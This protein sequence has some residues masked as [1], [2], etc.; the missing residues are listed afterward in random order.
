MA[1]WHWKLDETRPFLDMS[2]ASWRIMEDFPALPAAAMPAESPALQ[3][4]PEAAP[5]P[6]PV[7]KLTLR[8]GGDVGGLLGEPQYNRIIMGL[9][10]GL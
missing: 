6:P 4:P 10:I 3:M 8:R 2:F 1:S 5:A 7:S 9:M